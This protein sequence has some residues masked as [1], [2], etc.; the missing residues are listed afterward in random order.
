MY[1]QNVS[2]VTYGCTG[3]Q[4]RIFFVVVFLC[5]K[6]KLIVSIYVWSQ[7]IA[8]KGLV[9]GKGLRSRNCSFFLAINIVRQINSC[10]LYFVQQKEKN[11]KDSHSC[12]QA[13]K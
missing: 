9:E 11:K 3:M 5:V 13:I 12:R 4:V 1:Y 7:L 8:F 10:M 2:I 6:E